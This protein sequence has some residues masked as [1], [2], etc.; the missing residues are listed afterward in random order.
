MRPGAAERKGSRRQERELGVGEEPRGAVLA[1]CGEW[2]RW[3][4][5]RM[6]RLLREERKRP[7]QQRRGV[8]DTAYPLDG[9]TRLAFAE[10]QSAK[11]AEHALARVRRARGIERTVGA[12]VAALEHEAIADATV[13]RQLPAMQSTMMNGAEHHEIV[14]VVRSAIGASFDVV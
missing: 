10:S 8:A 6:H 4:R 1:H 3:A 9:A 12:A 13:N 7:A 14:S 11:S 5:S 2:P